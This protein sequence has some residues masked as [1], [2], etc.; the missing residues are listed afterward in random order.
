MIEQ[1]EK[2][3]AEWDPED[4]FDPTKLIRLFLAFERHGYV[5]TEKE[6]ST[7]T[8]ASALLD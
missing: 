1:T 3:V 6:C 4:G 2:R 7:I 5:L 8:F